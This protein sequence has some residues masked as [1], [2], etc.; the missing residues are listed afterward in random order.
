MRKVSRLHRLLSTTFHLGCKAV[1]QYA[2]YQLGLH[3]GFF[4]ART[5]A[6]LLDALQQRLPRQ[7]Q[8]LFPLPSP[9]EME[10]F[11]SKTLPALLDSAN[12][13]LAGH[14]TLF[15]GYPTQ[16]DLSPHTALLHWS[17][18]ERTKAYPGEDIKLVWEP[19]RFSWAF[20]LARAWHITRDS[21]YQ[22]ALQRYLAE[23]ARLNPP[24]M[25]INWTS[26]QEAA[27]R[28]L[29]LC[30][31]HQV[32]SQEPGPSAEL[33][34]SIRLA[35][36]LNA[37]RIPPTLCYARSQRNNHLIS[38]AVGLYSAG[39]LLKEYPSAPRWKRLGWK[40]FNQ[41]I[42][43]QIAAD[44][45]YIQH[46]ANYQRLMLDEAVWLAVL[47]KN[48]GEEL[49]RPIQEKLAA[50]TILLYNQLDLISGYSPNL[51]HQDGSNVLPLLEADHL[52]YRSTLQ[53]TGRLFLQQDL[54]PAGAWDEKSRWLGILPQP[55]RAQN[56]SSPLR[57]GN[58][59]DWASMRAV[60]YQSRPAHADQL[61]V[62]IWH[63]GQNL[64]LDA[65]TYLYNAPEPWCNALRSTRVHNTVTVDGLDQMLPTSR[66]MW[67]DWAN[68]H[69]LASDAFSIT[70]RHDGYR[71]LGIIHQRTLRHIPPA[72][73][74][75]NDVLQS[76]TSQSHRIYLHWLLPDLSFTLTEDGIR[77][78]DPAFSLQFS[79][80]LKGDARCSIIRAG[81][82]LAGH[83]DLDITH[84]GWFSPTYALK[85]PALSI[86]YGMDTSLPL[87]I[88]T[89]WQ[90]ASLAESSE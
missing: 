52:D 58:N 22:I 18:L 65:G 4:K 12:A 48:V 51:G 37:A 11:S 13:L 45:T 30:F 6:P 38:E 73:W 39:L 53:A 15:D 21:R 69:I 9:Q 82:W 16:L 36:A 66:F 44:G 67:L 87:T 20:T 5:S 60:S 54:F 77:F 29:A 61:H 7:G 31:A 79:N 55:I 84:Y 43:D 75:I 34:Q 1:S 28:I 32:F 74:E 56:P 78:K 89:L 24:Y 83:I 35:V 26:G 68:A 71:E 25:G 80:S 88:R 14:I 3:T 17:D 64:A 59:Q 33:L 40:I 50:S 57:L 27:L 72:N 23:F 46:S 49:P 10:S 90:F 81:T 63:A 8:S 47:A 62:E 86:L 19:A 41:A 42:Q 2:V 76:E 85:Q 70:A